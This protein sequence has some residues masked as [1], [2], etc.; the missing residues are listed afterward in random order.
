MEEHPGILFHAEAVV[1]LAVETI[2]LPPG[3]V[4]VALGYWAAYPEE[5]EQQIHDADE[6]GRLAEELRRRERRP[7]S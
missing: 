2:G 4:R 7:L 6:A 1:H 5:I 3:K